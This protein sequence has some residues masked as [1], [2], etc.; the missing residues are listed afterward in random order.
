MG[1]HFIYVF[2]SKLFELVLNQRRTIINAENVSIDARQ[3]K[4]VDVI[5]KLSI[6]TVMILVVFVF[7]V[8][9]FV[10]L[11][12]LPKD[13]T[14]EHQLAAVILVAFWEL[15][16]FLIFAVNNDCYFACCAKC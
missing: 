13:T 11:Y 8:I 2:N 1:A 3:S 4:L 15:A 6:M 12:S 10:V 14:I 7:I 9:V 16:M 5:T